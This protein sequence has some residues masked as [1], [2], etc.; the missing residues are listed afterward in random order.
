M[1]FDHSI[2]KVPE[3]AHVVFLLQGVEIGLI[4]GSTGTGMGGGVSGL[5][6]AFN[7]SR[8]YH[9]L[10]VGFGGVCRCMWV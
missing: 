7:L 5:K 3:A 9:R 6:S 8:S 4:L 2:A 10:Q 1:K